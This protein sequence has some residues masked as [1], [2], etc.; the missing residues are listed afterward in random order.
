MN[1]K[2]KSAEYN[3]FNKLSDEWWD[4]NGKFKILHT[5]RPI[6]IKYILDQLNKSSLKNLDILDLGC[7]GGLVSESLARLEGNVT[8]VDFVKNNI[9]V[10]RFHSIQN[11]L[12]I[13]YIHADIENLKVDKKFDL[14]ILF[15]ILEHLE[16][17]TKFLKFISKNLKKNGLIIISTINR[18]LISNLAA[19]F[20]AENLL[21]WVPKG[22]HSYEKFIKPYEIE[23]I[24][25]NTNNY[26]LKD[27]KGL[28]FNPINF[29]W[30]LQKNT[31]INYFCT[32]K[33][34][35]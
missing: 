16:D 31:S 7:G 18:N 6:R 32:Y 14:I 28:I 35:S 9:D 23:K 12:K 11:K 8:G 10:A 15:E 1:S 19:I 17:W 20:F 2:I 30:K 24:M 25:I 22:T 29:S 13:K 4:E 27:L 34:I 5:I 21:G 26:E 3:L 33:K